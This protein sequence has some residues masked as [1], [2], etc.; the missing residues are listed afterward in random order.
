MTTPMLM[1]RRMRNFSCHY[2]DFLT[3]RLPSMYS[4][5]LIYYTC[6]DDCPL[7]KCYFLEQ[8]SSRKHYATAC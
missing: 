4:I 1:R 5:I 8:G 3:H 6:N 7:S 2:E